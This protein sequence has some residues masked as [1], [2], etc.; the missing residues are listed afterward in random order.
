MIKIIQNLLSLKE[1]IEETMNI[2]QC[3]QP[4]LAA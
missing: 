2:E 1:V 3:H 4:I